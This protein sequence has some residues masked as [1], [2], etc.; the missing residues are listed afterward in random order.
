MW[1]AD[2]QT[3]FY[4]KKD[5]TT[6]R[7]Y[8]VQ[9]HRL[10]TSYADDVIM[11]TEGDETFYVDIHRSKSRRYVM[12]TMNSTLVSETLA[13]DANLPESQF[14]PVLPRAPETE[15]DVYHHGDSFYIRINQNAPNYRLIATPIDTPAEQ[16]QWREIIPH[17]QDVFLAD[18]EVFEDYLVVNER[19]NACLGLRVLPWEH[20]ELEYEI[21]FDDAVQVVHLDANPE[22][23]TTSLRFVYSSP[24]TPNAVYEFDLQ[25]R[26]RTLLKQDK[27]LG[28]FDSQNY[29]THRV[30]APA[31][32]GAKI[33]VSLITPKPLSRMERAPCICMRMVHTDIPWILGSRVRGLVCWTEGSLLQLPMCVV[34]RSS[35]AHGTTKAEQ[36]I[37]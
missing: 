36:F 4:V 21:D 32:D 14:R 12:V 1:A 35:A 8:Q 31:R 5:E 26:T 23:K 13:L 27:V 19:K 33:P 22:F 18:I 20:P 7:P 30:W 37:K 28:G 6:L 11:H 9:R 3:T 29:V 16:S 24:T 10:G 15:Y 2:N 17:R 25:K 34:V